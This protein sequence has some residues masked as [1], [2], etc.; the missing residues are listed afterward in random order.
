MATTERLLGGETRLDDK[1]SGIN[2]GSLERTVSVLAG[3]AVTLHGLRRGGTGGMLLALVGGAVIK[4]GVTGHC[5]VY[6]SLGV[7][8]AEPGADAQRSA[9]VDV[10]SAAT[11]GKPADELYRFWRDAGNL[12]RFMTLLEGVEVVSDRRARWKIGAPLG[13]TLE[14][15]AEITED[16]EGERI[17]WRSVEGAMVKH[18]GEVSFHSAPAGRGTEVRLRLNFTPPG[19]AVAAAVGSLFDGA[20]E[21]KLRGDLKRFKQ[22]V[23]TGEIA[24]TDGQPSGRA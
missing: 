24:T 4:R 15:E 22:L 9:G 14:F 12:P 21:M 2:V 16:V 6:G 11:I 23:E 19:G 1:S 18:T 5:D 7:S 20:A 13:R 10:S 8:T 17:A 3:S